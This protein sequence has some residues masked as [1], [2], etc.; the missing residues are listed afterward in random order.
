MLSDD[1]RHPTVLERGVGGDAPALLE[2]LRQQTVL[3]RLGE[4]A[5][6]AHR[7]DDILTRACWLVGEGLGTDVAAVMELDAD[8]VT[9]AVRAGAGL[10]SGAGDTLLAVD[11]TPERRALEGELASSFGGGVAVE[12][13][14]PAF[15]VGHGAASSASV[16]IAGG[17]GRPPFGILQVGSRAP[18]RFSEGDAVFLCSYARLLGGAVARMR[19]DEEVRDAETRLRLALEAGTLGSW[20]LDLASGRTTRSWRHDEIF[21][22]RD[23]L[24]A[25]SFE[26]FLGHVAPEEW[27]HVTDVFRRS[28]GTGAELRFEC[29]IRRADGQ[30]RWIEIRGKP[31]GGKPEGGKPEGHE[32]AP[33][34]MVGII[35]DITERK[36]ADAALQRSNLA[37]AASVAERTGELTEANTRLELEAEERERVEAALRQSQK[38]EA[39]GQLTGGLAHDFSNLLTGISGSLDLMRVRAE[40][41]RLGE[42]CRHIDVATAAAS[43]AAALVHRLLAFS[44]RQTLEPRP[45]LANGLVGGMSELF[46][47]TAGPGVRVETRLLE[48]LWPVLCDPNQLESALLNLVINARDAIMINARGAKPGG[49]R[50]LIET[51]NAVLPERGAPSER[52]SGGVPGGEYVAL[53]VIDDGAGMAAEVMARAFDPFFTTKPVGQGTGLG[54]S[55]TDGFVQQSGGH[56][57]MRSAEGRGTTVVIYLPRHLGAPK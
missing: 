34:R 38:M 47:R 9:L 49:G 10:G 42:V 14:D 24:P 30:M 29:R 17:E 28:T 31:E 40:Q 22:Y 36:Q 7:L 16:R 15:L 33:T 56:V 11:D 3:A 18:R 44:R 6:R 4:F 54:L 5:L 8:G 21:G 12:L 35:A 27:D 32:A 46:R 26:Q 43:R 1:L 48:G 13:G 50:I 39:V 19:H 57:R 20:E 52:P 53:S 2:R 45:V 23:A 37:L 25:W 51:A 55:M 41:G